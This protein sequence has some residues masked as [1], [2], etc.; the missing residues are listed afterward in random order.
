VVDQRAIEKCAHRVRQNSLSANLAILLWSF[1]A[2]ACAFTA[3]G[4]YNDRSYPHFLIV[5]LPRHASLRSMQTALPFAKRKDQNFS[6][7]RGEIRPFTIR[8]A[9]RRGTDLSKG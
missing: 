4:R 1:N 3:S 7:D 9:L 5:R 8:N 6:S 2:L